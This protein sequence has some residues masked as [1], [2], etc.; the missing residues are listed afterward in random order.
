LH[1]DDVLHQ[2]RQHRLQKGRCRLGASLMPS[3]T[4]DLYSTDLRCLGQ[5]IQTRLRM[6][7]VPKR[8]DLHK[9]RSAELTL[10]FHKTGRACQ[11]VC[12]LVQNVVQRGFKLCYTGRHKAPWSMKFQIASSSFK[13]LSLVMISKLNAYGVLF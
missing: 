5:L 1:A 13:E 12:S 3:R 6:M 9:I 10:P 4:A 8:Q 2:F 7:Q 11:F